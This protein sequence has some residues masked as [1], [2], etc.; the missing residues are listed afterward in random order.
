MKYGFILGYRVGELY[1]VIRIPLLEIVHDTNHQSELWHRNK[2]NP[3]GP[4]P[5]IGRR[6]MIIPNRME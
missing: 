5:S 6:S 3:R 4:F 1:R 2:E